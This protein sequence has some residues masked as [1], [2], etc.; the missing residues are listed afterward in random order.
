MIFMPLTIFNKDPLDDQLVWAVWVLG[1][2]GVYNK[3]RK[4][5]VKCLRSIVNS[6]AFIEI[7]EII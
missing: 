1:L 3:N 5:T 4:N 2:T 6:I 7:H